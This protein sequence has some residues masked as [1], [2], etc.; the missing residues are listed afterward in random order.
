VVEFLYFRAKQCLADGEPFD[1]AAL[2]WRAIRETCDLRGGMTPDPDVL[3][4][5]LRL[6]MDAAHALQQTDPHMA[7]AVWNILPAT[8]RRWPEV[9]KCAWFEAM[10]DEVQP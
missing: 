3:H 1:A 7:K 9:A 5:P 8:V 4:A 6:A 10:R 2:A